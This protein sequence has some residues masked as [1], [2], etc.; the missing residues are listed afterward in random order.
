MAPRSDTGSENG[1]SL[2]ALHFPAERELLWV[3]QNSPLFGWEVGQSVVFRNTSWV[4]L[5]RKESETSITLTLG[6]A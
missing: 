1:K 4:V 2:I 3:T 5:G 6:F